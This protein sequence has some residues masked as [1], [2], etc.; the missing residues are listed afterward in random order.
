MS[1]LAPA[2]RH[3]LEMFT[4]S[5]SALARASAAFSV[6]AH[7]FV[8]P[9]A[10]ADEL[11]RQIEDFAALPVPADELQVL[12]EYGNALADVV[13]RRLQ[14]LAVVL[15]RRVGVVEQLQ[16]RLRRHRSLAQNQRQN[17]PRRS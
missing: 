12:V 9:H 3:V 5:A 15:D 6:E 7:D 1:W 17:E 8:E 10:D 14:D 4:P 11:R 13:E 2:R 16:G